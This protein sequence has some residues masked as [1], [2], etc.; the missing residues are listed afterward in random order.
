MDELNDNQEVDE[1]LELPE[2]NEGDED[3]TDWKELALK[4]QGIN[5]RLKTKLDKIKEPKLPEK[6]EAKNSS[7]LGYGE[8][9]YLAAKNIEFDEQ[10]E[11]I[12][13]VMKKTGDTLKVV[14]KDD[15][16]LN[17]LKTL[18]DAKKVKEATPSNSKRSNSTPRDEVDY[19]LARGEMPPA[20]KPEL[21]RKYV[22]A[23]T[24]QIKDTD[25]FTKIP[26]VQ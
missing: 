24:T 23:K 16:V 22:N 2:V 6:P 3:T 10:I 21:R 7:E 1:T 17:K 19:W 4:Q 20:D 14:L 15:F 25:K 13:S 8:L 11:F 26:V 18:E 5:K 9:A 12:E